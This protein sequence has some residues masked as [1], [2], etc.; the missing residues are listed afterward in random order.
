MSKS[1][2]NTIE[3]FDEPKT[4]TKK[5][6]RIV[7][8][9]TPVE[10][11]KD[12]DTCNLLQLFRLFAAPDEIAAMEARYRAGGVGYGEVK[13]RLA[14]LIVGHFAEAREKRAELVANPAR[15]DEVRA[16]AAEKARKT[17]RAV[18]DRARDACGVAGR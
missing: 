6:K 10:E 13:G 2:D 18:L 8:D 4:I 17:A 15:V 7:T 5:V 1:Y 12:P 16:A 11:P 14:E 9:S 3:I